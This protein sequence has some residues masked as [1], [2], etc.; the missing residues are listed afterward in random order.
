MYTQT[1]SVGNDT[2]NTMKKESTQSFSYEK[3]PEQNTQKTTNTQLNNSDYQNPQYVPINPYYYNNNYYNVYRT[4]RP[5]YGGGIYSIGGYSY[6]IGGFNYT[7]HSYNYG[8]GK[9]PIYV[10]T[11]PRPIPPPNNKPNPPHQNGCGGHG[12]HQ[13]PSN[14]K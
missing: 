9:R 4:I 12:H 10:T 8:S 6:S 11:P 3:F 13:P 7:G 1:L 5:Y 14:N 2:T